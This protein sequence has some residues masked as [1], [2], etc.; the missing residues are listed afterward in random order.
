LYLGLEDESYIISPLDSNPNVC[1][2]FDLV[3]VMKLGLE[4]VFASNWKSVPILES[5]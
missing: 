3:S 5:L 2:A 4:S 1:L